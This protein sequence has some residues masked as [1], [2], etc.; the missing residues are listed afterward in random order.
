MKLVWVLVANAAEAE[1]YSTMKLR[2]P[3]T[4][5][6]TMTHDESKLHARELAADG[7]GRVHDRIG[8]NRHAMEPDTDA[9]D[10]EADRFAAEITAILKSAHHRGEFG[11]LA[12]IAAP[13]FLG[14][15]RKA[16]GNSIAA[17]QII[18]QIAKDVVGQDV[19]HIRAQLP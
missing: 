5:L 14:K 16:I 1:I 11:R 10:K 18:A 13:Q 4:L 15:L 6:K 12:I 3:L 19:E 7:P 9:K 8:E 2:G 17:D